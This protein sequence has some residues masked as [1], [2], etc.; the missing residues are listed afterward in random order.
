MQPEFVKIDVEGHELHVLKGFGNQ[1]GSTQM[2][3]IERGERPE[4]KT[5]LQKAGY[6]GP[7]FF[8]FKQK[9]MRKERQA[10]EED[11]IYVENQ[12][13]SELKAMGMVIG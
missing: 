13:L 2:F 8:H 12:Y 10:R 11:S 1:M 7:W 3:F 5:L 9:R 6:N 4:I